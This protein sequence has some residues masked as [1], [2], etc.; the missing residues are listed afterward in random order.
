M[1]RARTPGFSSTQLYLV[2]VGEDLLSH[3]LVCINPAPGHINPMLTVSQHLSGAG[4][5]VTVLTGD[6]FKDKIVAAG[7]DFVA[8][9]GIA[10]FDYRRK[11]ISFRIKRI[12]E[13]WTSWSTISRTYLEIR[14]QIKTDA[15]VRSWPRDQSI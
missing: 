5:H 14:Y 10:N 7:L 3:I 1:K 15:S 2:S 9:T 4:H 8:V 6:V 11:K 12:S 13:A